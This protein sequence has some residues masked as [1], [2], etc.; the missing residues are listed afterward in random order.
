M[1]GQ[2][3]LQPSGYS[4]I[5]QRLCHRRS[6]RKQ[7]GQELDC[8]YFI[9]PDGKLEFGNTL[10]NNGDTHNAGNATSISICL[11]GQ[12][13]ID[14]TEMQRETLRG[15]LGNLK[16]FFPKAELTAEDLALDITSFEQQWSE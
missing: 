12:R 2:I 15:L 7:H 8:H 3:I 16:V 11:A 9:G 13:A 4:G 14:F 6:Y 1:P 10:D 5:E